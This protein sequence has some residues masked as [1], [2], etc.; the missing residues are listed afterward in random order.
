MQAFRSIDLQKDLRDVLDS[1]EAE[2]T[3]L[4]NR[5]QPRVI[6]MSGVEFRRLKTAAGEPIPAAV[7]PSRPLV[8]RGGSDDPLGYDTS[9]IRATAKAMADDVLSGKTAAAIGA[10]RARVRTS[11]GAS[12][13]PCGNGSLRMGIASE[14]SRPRQART[15]RVKCATGRG[16][17]V[18]RRTSQAGATEG[19]PV[20]W[21]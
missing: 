4:V 6:L 17:V 10:E 15:M 8:L 3:V 12:E 5:G 9:D 2:P 13:R 11:A 16:A 18:S 21:R 20:C 7:L 1:A 19:K 14:F